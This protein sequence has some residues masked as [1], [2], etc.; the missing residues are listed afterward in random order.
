MMTV[1]LQLYWSHVNRILY[2]VH[3]RTF[4]C[5]FGGKCPVYGRQ[6]PAALMYAM[7]GCGAQSLETNTISD[8][9]KLRLCRDYCERSR[10][11]LLSGLSSGTISDL[12][13]VQ[14]I[15]VIFT[16]LNPSGKAH[17]ALGLLQCA[18]EVGKH[19][20]LGPGKLTWTRGAAPTNATE[21][22]QRDM[23][24]RCWIGVCS[25]D[26]E[27]AYY[28]GRP[29][30]FDWFG[31]RNCE[32]PCHEIFL[33]ASSAEQAYQ[34]THGRDPVIVDFTAFNIE[35]T[36]EVGGNIARTIVNAVFTQRASLYSL[37]HFNNFLRS[38]RHQ[39]FHFATTQN[40]DTLKILSQPLE[41]DSPLERL[42]MERVSVF[43]SIVAAAFDALPLGIGDAVYSGDVSRFFTLCA[44]CF[45]DPA[46]L[47]F[48]FE[49]LVQIRGYTLQHYFQEGQQSVGAEVFS[50][51]R[52][53]PILESSLIFT[54]ML[55]G[56][57][58][59]DPDLEWGHYLV[60]PACMRIVALNMASIVLLRAH[61]GQTDGFEHDVRI[62]FRYLEGVARRFGV[63][64]RRVVGMFRQTLVE[65][66][67][68]LGLPRL[69]EVDEQPPS[70][71][72]Q[73][74]VKGVEPKNAGKWLADAVRSMDVKLKSWVS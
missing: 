20:W 7:L 63:I 49:L 3:Q 51:P 24:L 68:E 55:E 19:R 44:G 28:A 1:C 73:M 8:A 22:I 64:A 32:L 71:L 43:E 59:V 15:L 23:A 6:A 65:A 10:Q 70:N 69:E 58:R 67:I 61:G 35:P 42:Y 62:V 39:L 25:L 41:H 37:L 46:Q 53:L 33:G 57:L 4:E 45:A 27:A 17:L 74:D 47:H 26:V 14:T 21:W 52:F 9:E 48:T 30:L 72:G 50:S 18:V 54:Q 5:A 11:L 38:L 16:V 36:A 34:S 56:Q 60:Y 31:H 13:A 12:E 2:Y 29:P 40:I 66:G